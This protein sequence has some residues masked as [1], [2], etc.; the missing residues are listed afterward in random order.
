MPPRRAL[1]KIIWSVLLYGIS[2]AL[3]VDGDY[4]DWW[5][6]IWV[7]IFVFLSRLFFKWRDKGVTG[8]RGVVEY[9]K[10]KINACCWGVFGQQMLRVCALWMLLSSTRLIEFQ[11]MLTCI[12]AY[13]CILSLFCKWNICYVR[14]TVKVT[15]ALPQK[16]SLWTLTV[17]NN[18][19]YFSIFYPVLS[20]LPGFCPSPCCF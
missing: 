17:T 2:M 14:L 13:I 16:P 5:E 19:N 1:Q 18:L 12:P 20:L 4:R 10:R 11:I 9:I 15:A 7:E 8:W 3:Y 6:G